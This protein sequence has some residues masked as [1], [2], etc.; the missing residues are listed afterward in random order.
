M[1][2]DET[3]K[4]QNR[5]TT[6]KHNP[7]TEN[8]VVETTKKQVS[9]TRM[10]KD[11]NVLLNKATGEMSGTHVVTY[12]EV[13]DSEF[14]KLFTKNIGLAFD[15]TSAGLK[16][17]LLMAFGLQKQVEKEGLFIDELLLEDFLRENKDKKV[18]MKTIYRGLIELEKCKI[19]A[20][21]TRSGYYF[22][23]PN[24]VFNGNRLAFTTEIQ[25]KNTKEIKEAIKND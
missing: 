23:N 21:S 15:L 10:G 22:T 13:D 1:K 8:L 17:L 5:L 14:I 6:Y 12:R 24:F 20:K 16:A 9:V 7:F 19:L 25:R 11:D 3:S 4:K 18:S 2:N